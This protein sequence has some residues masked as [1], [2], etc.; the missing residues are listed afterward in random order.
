M[1]DQQSLYSDIHFCHASKLLQDCLGECL[2]LYKLVKW[3]TCRIMGLEFLVA[4]SLDKNSWLL[5]EDEQHRTFLPTNQYLM[6]SPDFKFDTLYLYT[7]FDYS[8]FTRVW[9]QSGLKIVSGKYEEFKKCIPHNC[10]IVS[11]LYNQRLSS[12]CFYYQ[13]FENT[14]SRKESTSPMT[15]TNVVGFVQDMHQVLSDNKVGHFACASLNE[16]L[17]IHREEKNVTFTPLFTAD[18]TY[19]EWRNV[20]TMLCKK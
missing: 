15:N 20:T 3:L 7:H 6:C 5:T 8:E 1:C 19:N 16:L 9:H 10:S 14:P 17:V 18:L 2:F 12:G 11:S 4:F 13:S